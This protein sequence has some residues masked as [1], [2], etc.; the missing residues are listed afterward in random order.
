M[1]DSFL[2]LAK[3]YLNTLNFDDREK[4]V[5]RVNNSTDLLTKALE[6][7]RDLSRSLNSDLIRN[8][9]LEKAIEQQVIQLEKTG[10][11]HVIFE[12]QG[13]NIYLTE[14]KEIISVSDF[15]GSSQ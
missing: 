1:L 2:S 15:A 10:R 7:L 4:A 3:L 5:D 13:D 9:G 6:D 14:Q 12:V 11:Y 8:G